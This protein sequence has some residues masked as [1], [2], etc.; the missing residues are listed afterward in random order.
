MKNKTAKFTCATD[1][2]LLI[3]ASKSRKQIRLTVKQRDGVAGSKAKM[4]P[5]HFYELNEEEKAEKHF[6]EL[7]EDAQKK[8]W[9]LQEKAE[10]SQS[11]KEIPAAPQPKVNDAKP[12]TKS[13]PGAKPNGKK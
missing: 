2:T 11:F 9:T 4:G 10:R 12:D 6:E 8:G 13:G 1:D 7:V 5:K 3:T